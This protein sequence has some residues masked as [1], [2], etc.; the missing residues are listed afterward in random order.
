MIAAMIGYGSAVESEEDKRERPSTAA[1]STSD[2]EEAQVSK[3]ERKS[4]KEKSW[5]QR[6]RE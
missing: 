1:Q 5:S 4:G 3:R 6:R 2:G